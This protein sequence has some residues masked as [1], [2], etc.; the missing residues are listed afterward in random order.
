MPEDTINAT[1][2]I[3][4]SINNCIS[5]LVLFAFCMVLQSCNDSIMRSSD[6]LRE[7]A[8]KKVDDIIKRLENKH[9]NVIEPNK[10][11]IHSIHNLRLNDIFNQYGNV[12]T[13][14]TELSSDA[15]IIY[16]ITYSNENTSVTSNVRI[17]AVAGKDFNDAR[18]KM[19]FNAIFLCSFSWEHHINNQS[20]TMV[21]T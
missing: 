17:D 20:T 7:D 2:K 19:F 3:D 4:M 12:A 21:G 15:R 11:T 14:K 1:K 5:G 18:R 8:N 6:P 9:G 13:F 16:N 10:N